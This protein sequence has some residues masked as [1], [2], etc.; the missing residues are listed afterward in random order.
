MKPIVAGRYRHYKGRDYEVL[1][2]ARHSE[3]GEEMV[4]Y[5]ALYGAR[6]LWVRPLSMF[7]ETVQ[8]EGR[9]VPRFVWVGAPDVRRIG[10]DGLRAAR[11]FVFAHGR[12][13]E[14][15]LL[16]AH[17]DAESADQV[18][19]HLSEYRNADG[20]FGHALEPDLRTPK[21]SVLATS[22]AFQV[23]RAIGAPDDHPLVRD[24]IRYLLGAFDAT[25]GVWP[26]I[27][28]TANDAPHA[29]WWT[30]GP[31]HPAW[32]GG[33]LVNPRAE[34][35]GHLYHY[36]NLVEQA[37]LDGVAEALRLDLEDRTK[38]LDM[39]EMLCAVR[40]EAVEGIPQGLRE[41][42]Q[43]AI[44]WSLPATLATTAEQWESY[45]LQPLALAPDPASH[46]AGALESLIDA[47]LDF[48]I[49][50]QEIGGAWSPAW[51]W[52]D[53]YPDRWQVAR[54]DWQGVLTLDAMRQLAAWGRVAS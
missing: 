19:A 4:V 35:V 3:S 33:Y 16:R 20:G 34:V 22:T 49:D 1:S 30:V 2:L 27:P 8:F 11:D 32:F 52:G 29:P 18:Y 26:I 24:G 39:N 28:A 38:P 41:A 31:D 43:R 54:R 45:S 25:T 46:L 36:R 44:E 12:P 37:W 21:S 23:L 15:A 7:A 14:R 50:E 42:A 6:G 47:N 9:N 53:L 51:S 5:R 17:F 40:L 10:P 13:L 48:R